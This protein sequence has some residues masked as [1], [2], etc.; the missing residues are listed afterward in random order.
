MLRSDSGEVSIVFTQRYSD[1]EEVIWHAKVEGRG[2]QISLEQ[3]RWSGIGQQSGGF[4]AQRVGDGDEARWSDVGVL[5]LRSRALCVG[6]SLAA[7]M[8]ALKT[9]DPEGALVSPKNTLRKTIEEQGEST[10]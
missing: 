3:G 6:V 2:S 10:I 4:S 9:H 7:V 5:Q 1:G 8:R